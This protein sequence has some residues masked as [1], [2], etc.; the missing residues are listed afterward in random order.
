MRLNR[1]LTA[2]A[3]VGA[4]VLAVSAVPAL[5]HGTELQAALHGSATYP[6]TRGHVDYSRGSGHRDLHV[7]AWHMGRL[8]GKTVTVYAGGVKVGTARVG[9]LGRCHFERSTDHGQRVPKLGAGATIRIRTAGGT[10]VASGV[11]R[12][13]HDG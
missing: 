2:M 7:E 5:G 12:A 8:A 6:N 4:M 10:L 1:I 3:V 9:Q 11:L 13:H